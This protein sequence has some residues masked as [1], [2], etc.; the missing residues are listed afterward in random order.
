V[1]ADNFETIERWLQFLETKSNDNL[2]GRWGGRWDFLGDWLWPAAP[3]SV[4]NDT[5]ETLFFNNCNWIHQLQL[6]ANIARILGQSAQASAWEKRASDV[7]QAVH[8]KFFNAADH[9]YVNG[10]Q[11]YLAIALYVHVPP[12]ELRPVVW[13]R[14]EHEILDVRGGHIHAGI[15][16]GSFLF[17]TLLEGRRD[18]LLHAMVSKDSYPSWGDL[19]RHDATTFWESWEERAG[20]SLMHSSYLY[21]G[22]WFMHGVLG[23]QPDPQ[24][25]GYKRFIIRPGPVDQPDLTWAKGHFDSIQGR[26]AVDWRRTGE[27]FVLEVGVPPNTTAVIYLPTT[28]PE[29]ITEGDRALSTGAE[30]KLLR[31]ENDR[32]LLEVPSGHY[33]FT[34]KVG[35]K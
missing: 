11:A 23:I 34:C 29:S 27:T 6:G 17:K 31:R 5:P 26:I 14:L 24:E 33:R 15:I 16:G 19:L 8:R 4:G 10:D 13:K 25:M 1:L 22:A 28:T 9:S 2:L 35:T 18:D 21:V 3:G 20:H 32:T 30:V 12:E 7:R